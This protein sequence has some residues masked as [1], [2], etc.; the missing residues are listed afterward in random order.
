MLPEQVI[1]LTGF[2]TKLSQKKSLGVKTNN[3]GIRHFLLEKI[4][5]KSPCYNCI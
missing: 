4:L 5:I 1:E 2:I 3:L